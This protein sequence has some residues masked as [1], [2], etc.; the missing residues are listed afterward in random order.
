MLCSGICNT[1]TMVMLQV[2]THV[3]SILQVTAAG[4]QQYHGPDWASWNNLA[5]QLQQAATAP[6]CY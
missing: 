2:Y 4:I 5:S 6:T 1:L 3:A